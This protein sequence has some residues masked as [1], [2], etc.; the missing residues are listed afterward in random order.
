MEVRVD[1]SRLLDDSLTDKQVEKIIDE[2]IRIG[3]PNY[4]TREEIE[5]AVRGNYEE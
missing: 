3:F 2:F 4:A 5:H 1:L